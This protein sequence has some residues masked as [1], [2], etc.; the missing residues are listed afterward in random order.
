MKGTDEVLN[1][2]KYLDSERVA[3]AG[4]SYGGFNKI[5]IIIIINRYMMNWINGHT[6]RFK[7][8][9]IHAGTFDLKSLYFNTE[10]LWFPEWDMGGKPWDN[11]NTNEINYY[12]KYNPSNFI[13]NWKTPSLVIQ[14][15]KD[16][17]IVE[18]EVFFSFLIF[19]FFIV[20]VYSHYQHSMYYKE[21][22]L[23]QDFYI[24]QM[25]IIGF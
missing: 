21:K 2:F 5:K 24:F 19:I 25:K 8:L 20:V 14:G 7:C 4:A 17:R 15:G 11:A 22:E 12:D 13:S 6:D 23:H 1:K 18:T 3:A 9:I 16:F 10:E